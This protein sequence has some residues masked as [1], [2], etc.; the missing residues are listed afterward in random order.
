MFAVKETLILCGL[1]GFFEEYVPVFLVE[2]GGGHRKSYYKAAELMVVLGAKI[3]A[4]RNLKTI[5]LLN[6]IR[7]ST[8][9]VRN[10]FLCLAV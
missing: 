7:F 8:N 6:V 9:F 10:Y 5:P 1:A 2:I 4:E 3:E